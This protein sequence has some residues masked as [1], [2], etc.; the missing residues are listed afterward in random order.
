MAWTETSLELPERL[1]DE[2]G[3]IGGGSPAAASEWQE[4]IDRQLV[5]WGRD[6]DALA[7][8]GI[9][10]PSSATIRL[11]RRVAQ[12]TRDAGAP[13]PSRVVIDGAGGIAFERLD[14]GIYETLLVRKDG[15]VEALAFR[16]AALL[17]RNRIREAGA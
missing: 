16:G 15:S 7:D 11:A 1:R 4:I 3:W 9:E 5:E 2:P 13:P 10:P 8:E 12:A 14:S 17:S 6:P